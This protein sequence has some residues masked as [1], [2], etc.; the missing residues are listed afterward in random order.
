MSKRKVGSK[1]PNWSDPQWVASAIGYRSRPDDEQRA[2]AYL[3]IC[4][5]YRKP[6]LLQKFAAR[7]TWSRDKARR[8][9]KQAGVEIFYP[10]GRM[11][12]RA[13]V[14]YLVLLPKNKRDPKTA[15]LRIIT[16]G[17]YF[18]LS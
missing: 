13:T 8:F 3:T 1:D 18:C 9:L 4:Y 17:Y 11:C 7:Y 16:H 2:I 12:G 14:G 15:H 5:K 10:G 6:I